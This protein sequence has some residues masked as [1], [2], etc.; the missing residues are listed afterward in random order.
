MGIHRS[1]LRN[2]D[3]MDALETRARNRVPKAMERARRDA[4]MVEKIKA[5]E[6]PYAPPVMSWLSFRLDKQ[7]SKI[8]QE[9]VKTLLR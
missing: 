7:A 9:D 1:H 8:T 6:L 5:G 4:R 3:R 2:R